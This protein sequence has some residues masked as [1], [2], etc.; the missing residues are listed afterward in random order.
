MLVRKDYGFLGF[1]ALVAIGLLGGCVVQSTGSTGTGGTDVKTTVTVGVGGAG[2]AGGGDCV[3]ETGT[4]VI[5]DCD[6]LNITPPSHGGGATASCGATLDQEPPGYGLCTLSFT[7]F[8]PGATTT[9]VECLKTIGVE[10][11]CKEEPLQA[12]IDKAY[13]AECP[14]AAVQTDCDGIKTTCGTDPFDAVQCAKDLNILSDEGLMKLSDCIN[15]A[16]PALTCQQ[17]Y[18]GCR[19]KILAF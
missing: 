4:A 3:G 10:S 18:D 5:A 19:D 1:Q 6:H 12:C 15:T 13:E 14:I 2:G 17:A 16:D 8:N 9:L 7:L 11:R